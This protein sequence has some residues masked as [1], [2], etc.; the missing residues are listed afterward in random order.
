MKDQE[1][2]LAILL[3]TTNPVEAD[4]IKAKLESFGIPCLLK[5]ES[6]GH[7]YGVMID[8]LAA[9]RILV[10]EE[11]LELARQV[12]EPEELDPSDEPSS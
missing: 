7:L 9:V 8:G 11:C 12:I 2:R 5:R 4:V 1:G 10:P 6:A 3:E